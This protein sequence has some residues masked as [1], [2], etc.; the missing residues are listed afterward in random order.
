MSAGNPPDPPTGVPGPRGQ[1]H[2]CSDTAY[3]E[4]MRGYDQR[5]YGDRADERGDRE[6]RAD[7]E[8]GPCHERR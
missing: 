6:P 1:P 5:Y 3:D 2:Y 4:Y 8:R 7:Y